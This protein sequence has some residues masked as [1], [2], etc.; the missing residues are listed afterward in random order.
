[1]ELMAF[2]FGNYLYLQR[3]LLIINMLK[4]KSV[5]IKKISDFAEKVLKYA[6]LR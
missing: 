1:M 2:F 5:E 3:I 6:I 4:N